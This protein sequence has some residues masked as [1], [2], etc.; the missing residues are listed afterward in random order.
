[1]G[2]LPRWHSCAHACKEGLGV[3][4]WSTQGTSAASSV[5][6]SSF[7][8]FSSDENSTSLLDTALDEGAAT[9]KW[10]V[11]GLAGVG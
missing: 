11:L 1:M 9:F 7:A 10:S 8:V 4:V 5:M 3:Q 2:E 6:Q